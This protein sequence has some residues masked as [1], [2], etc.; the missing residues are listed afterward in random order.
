M[1]LAARILLTLFAIAAFL[2]FRDG[3]L[4][5]WLAA[6]FLNAGE[7]DP[8]SSF[9]VGRAPFGP[10]APADPRTSGSSIFSRPVV[11]PIISDFGDPRDGGSR[12]HEGIDIEAATGT[13][14]R[15]A[16]AGRV[17]RAGHAGRC[18]KRVTIDHGN[19]W[20]TLY[21]HL[22]SIDIRAGTDVGAGV[23]IGTVGTT[24]NAKGGVPHLHF[25]IRRNGDPQPN[26]EQLIGG[27]PFFLEGV[28]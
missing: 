2:N 22:D 23:V 27:T 4:R 8:P 9:Q 14:V 12:T 25:E 6:K 17:V 13:P 7:A 19:G 3:R 24:G 20:E 21:C 28:G 18:G 1:E 5:D 10:L 15:A 11:G 16:R 26:V